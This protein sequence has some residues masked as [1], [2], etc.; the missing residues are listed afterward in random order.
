MAPEAQSY[1]LEV[2]L[3]V[4]RDRRSLY[5]ILYTIFAPTEEASGVVR[6]LRVR[7]GA[8]QELNS[9]DKN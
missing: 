5:R 6:I 9:D 8:R 3:L 4:Y 7:Q 2:R 1:G